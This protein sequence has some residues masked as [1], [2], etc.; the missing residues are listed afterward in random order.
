MG[1]YAV[2]VQSDTTVIPAVIAGTQRSPG[3]PLCGPVTP[4]AWVTAGRWI[5]GTS[6]G[7]TVDVVGLPSNPRGQQSR[8]LSGTWRRGCQNSGH[9]MRK[10]VFANIGGT[11][12]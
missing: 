10:P 5:P 7:I 4:V 11:A 2:T 1:S 6:P 3:S 12:Q 9:S 8:W